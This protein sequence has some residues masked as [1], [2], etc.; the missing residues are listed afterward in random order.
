VVI[1]VNIRV[2]VR[3]SNREGCSRANC[4][5]SFSNSHCCQL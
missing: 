1:R 3:V 5:S 2:R 4:P